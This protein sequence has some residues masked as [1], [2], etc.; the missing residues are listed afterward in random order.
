MVDSVGVGAVD[1]DDDDDRF[2]RRPPPPRPP[3]AFPLP[4][5]PPLP[6]LFPEDDDMVYTKHYA[7]A[8]TRT[9]TKS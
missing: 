8:H 2:P 3:L 6:L 7:H 1:D 5:R 9:H 4:P